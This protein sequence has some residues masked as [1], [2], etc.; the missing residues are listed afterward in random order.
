MSHPQPPHVLLIDDD[1]AVLGLVGDALTHFG[2]RVHPFSEA[3]RALRLLED[4][5]S[6]QFDLVISDINMDG[7]DGFDVINRV[8]STHPN[9]PVVLMTGQ[10]SLDYAI[11]AM[12][13]GAANLFQKPLTIRELVNSVFHLVDLHREIRLAE[14]GLRGMV[15]ERRVFRARADE[16]DIPSLVTHLTDRLVPMGFAKATNVD[17]IAMAFH[18]AL[19]NALEH[20]CLEL[21]SGLKGDLFAEKD[22]YAAQM[23]E[24][25]ADPRY[26]HRHIEI[27]SVLTGDSFTVAI[28]DGGPGFDTATVANISDVD[29][30]RQCGRGLPLILLVMDEVIH[31]PAGNEIRLV[32]AKKEA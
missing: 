17:V 19:V 14:S 15:E 21:D 28:R 30:N 32:L 3:N 4:P 6:P 2:M 1:V 9:L 23:Q 7:M 20:G 26:A 22:A 27:E 24:R 10:A 31:N 18:E 16:L 8:K 5:E 11:R 29:L 12:R 25:L 13:M